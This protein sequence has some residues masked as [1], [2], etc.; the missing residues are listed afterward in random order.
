[1][2]AGDDGTPAPDIVETAPEDGPQGSIRPEAEEF[3]LAIHKVEFVETPRGKHLSFSAVRYVLRP[4]ASQ[5]N[6]S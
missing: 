2:E 3:V 6:G 5:L 4:S 1:M